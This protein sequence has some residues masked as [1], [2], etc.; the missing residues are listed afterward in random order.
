MSNPLSTALDYFHKLPLAIQNAAKAALRT[1]IGAELLLI[2]AVLAAPN[3]STQENLF[4]AGSFAAGAA[5]VRLVEQAI[6]AW[7]DSRVS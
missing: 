6:V 5:A 7:L 1:F 2:P 4:L 3:V